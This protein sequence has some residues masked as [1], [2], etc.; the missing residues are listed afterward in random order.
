M[1]AGLDAGYS[2]Y[3]DVCGA[4]W[5]DS[6]DTQEKGDRSGKGERPGREV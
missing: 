5:K 4:G 1:E 2:R 6:P 3:A